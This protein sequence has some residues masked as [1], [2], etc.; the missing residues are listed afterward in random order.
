MREWKRAASKDRQF[1]EARRERQRRAEERRRAHEAREAALA[2][3]LARPR[4]RVEEI[5]ERIAGRGQQPS[6]RLRELLSVVAEKAPRLLAEERRQAFAQMADAPWFRPLSAWKPLGKGGESLFRSIAAHLFARYPMPPFLWSA[7]L[8]GEGR[9][10]LVDVALHVAS[11]GS[12]YEAVKTGLMPVPLT[13]RMC[14]EALVRGGEGDVLDVVRRVQVRAVGGSGRLLRAWLNTEGGA[15]VHDR[16]GETFWQT[17]LAWFGAN[18]MLPT[19][20]VGPLVDYIAHRRRQDPAFSMKGRSVL[21][22]LRGTREW[23]GTL[24][25]QSEARRR[26]FKPSGFQP[27]DLDRSRKSSNGKRLTE[28][29]HLR[30]VLDSASLADEGRTMGHCV[31][32][33]AHSIERGECSIWTLTLEDGTGH[34]RRLTIEVRNNARRIVQ[35]RG[36]FNKLPQPLDLIP[37]N[38]WAAQNRLEIAMGPC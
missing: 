3:A 32:S 11:G 18:P 15:R 9:A 25:R 23:H 24:A 30:E 19:S 36:R 27:M 12:L 35:A 7:F 14:H 22:L 4:P 16:E 26:V 5:V 28:V 8:A 13:R 1:I 37:L 38:A 20:E 21:A 10:V 29:W 2:E 33:Y 6:A 31:Y 34:W 17:V